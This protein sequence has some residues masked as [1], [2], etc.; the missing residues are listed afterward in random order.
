MDIVARTITK[1]SACC[2]H[3]RAHGPYRETMQSAKLAAFDEGWQDPPRIDGRLQG[4]RTLCPTCAAYRNASTDAREIRKRARARAYLVASRARAVG[5]LTGTEMR[6][7]LELA[8][9]LYPQKGDHVPLEPRPGPEPSPDRPDREEV[10][11]L[12]RILAGELELC[13]GQSPPLHDPLYRHWALPLFGYVWHFWV[14][15][16]KTLCNRTFQSAHSPKSIQGRTHY[17]KCMRCN[18][19]YTRLLAKRTEHAP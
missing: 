2:S 4:T 17:P 1:Y 14:T 5:Q 19:E 7:A 15:P 11:R 18:R 10:D 6:Q 12:Y 3:C 13:F 9:I 8:D 16:N